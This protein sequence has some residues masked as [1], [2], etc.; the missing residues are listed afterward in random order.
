MWG[1]QQLQP[2]DPKTIYKILNST[3]NQIG[4]KIC[5]ILLF[6]QYFG[7]GFKTT[8]LLCLEIPNENLA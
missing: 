3:L 8:F 1:C 2:H 4:F 5:T 6:A 7:L